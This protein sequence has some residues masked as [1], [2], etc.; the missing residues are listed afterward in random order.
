MASLVKFTPLSGCWQEAAPRCYLLEVD[1]YKLLLDCGLPQPDGDGVVSVDEQ[2]LRAIKRAAKSVDAVLLSHSTWRHLGAL[3]LIIHDLPN[4]TPIFATVP[5]HH[6]GLMTLYD[7][8]QSLEPFWSTKRGHSESKALFGLDEVDLAFERIRQ[9]RYLQSCTIGGQLIVV[10]L[11][12]GHSLGGAMWRIRRPPAEDILYAVDFNHRREA[13]ID[14][15]QFV[16][17]NRPSVLLSDASGALVSSGGNIRKDRD[18]AL[19]RTLGTTLASGGSVLIPSDAAQRILEVALVIDSFWSEIAG[20]SSS[21]RVFLLTQQSFR[22]VE[23]AKGLLEWMSPAILKVF[24]DDRT[25][26]FDFN[27]V[28][29]VHRVEDV[30]AAATNGPVVVLATSADLNTGLSHSLLQMF[31]KSSSN[32]ILSLNGT[33][34]HDSLLWELVHGRAKDVV[35]R[36]CS[37]VPLEGTELAAYY[38]AQREEAEKKAAEAAFAS[39][40]RSRR[41]GEL[42]VDVDDD[43]DEEG[44]TGLMERQVEDATAFRNIFWVDYRHD[45]FNDPS[46]SEPYQK[47]LTEPEKLG[48]LYSQM[49]SARMRFQA[50]PVREVFRTIDEYGE[51]VSATEFAAGTVINAVET[52]DETAK[53][54][55]QKASP[56][57]Q[58]EEIP[59]KW[60]VRL[61]KLPVKCSRQ[62][63]AGFEGI[64]DGRSLK[65]LINRINPRK[66]VL[67]A[68]NNESTSFLFEHYKLN[69]NVG[70][71]STVNLVGGIGMESFAPRVLESINIS[72]AMNLTSAVLSESLLNSLRVAYAQDCEVSHLCAKLR[73]K[74]RSVDGSGEEMPEAIKMQVDETLVNNTAVD[75]EMD[76]ELIPCDSSQTPAAPSILI[77]EVR[78]NELR[79]LLSLKYPSLK[80]EFTVTGDLICNDRI[81]IRRS[82]AGPEGTAGASSNQPLTVEGPICAEFYQIRNAI[83]DCVTVI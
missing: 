71:A 59:C 60:M 75:K 74:T 12:A 16:G 67:I 70:D 5:V 50:F 4:N 40:A 45:W 51:I 58:I 24:E 82:H 13:H 38:A 57:E 7:M 25:N 56:T 21:A 1:N 61:V 23:F 43:E 77:G 39:L 63:L 15:A 18:A 14:G 34:R 46:Q 41:D 3:P 42:A 32:L 30:L 76:I 49:G 69:S 62:H 20:R 10:P 65:T 26:P 19:M 68:G 6:L 17:V 55:I 33:L 79:R 73:L 27:H 48:G 35:I 81:I 9:L 80:T 31:A 53:R 83:Y 44:L 64:S 37:R 2:Y 8:L 66:L 47:L 29:L 28:N 54:K 11:P 78:L 36:T 72:S 22:T 52:N